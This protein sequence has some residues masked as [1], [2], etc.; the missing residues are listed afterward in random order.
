MPGSGGI[1]GG[2]CF[3]WFNVNGQG[4]AASDDQGISKIKIT[5]PKGSKKDGQNVAN[6]HEIEVELEKGQCILFSWGGK[7]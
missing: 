3:V 7:P 2:S 4:W 6:S 1:G 5:L